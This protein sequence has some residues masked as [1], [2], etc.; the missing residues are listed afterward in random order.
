MSILGRTRRDLEKE[1]PCVIIIISF[2]VPDFFRAGADGFGS[3]SHHPTDVFIQ[4]YSP[5][6]LTILL[7]HGQE[8]ETDPTK[9]LPGTVKTD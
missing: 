6:T 5:I 2:H 4:P 7:I 3:A 9:I 1:S 8:T